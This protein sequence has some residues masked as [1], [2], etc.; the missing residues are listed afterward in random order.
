LKGKANVETVEEAF[1]AIKG[2]WN[3]ENS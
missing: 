3:F 1:P 2:A